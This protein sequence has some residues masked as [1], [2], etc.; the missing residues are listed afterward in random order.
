M[1]KLSC[2]L[3]AEA[4]AWINDCQWD[5]LASAGSLTDGQVVAGV[6]RHYVGGWAQFVKDGA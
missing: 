5:D 2:D 4:R 1:L 6:D 3:L